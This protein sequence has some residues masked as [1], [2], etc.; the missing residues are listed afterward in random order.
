MTD[1]TTSDRAAIPTV[2]F[3]VCGCCVDHSDMPL[4]AN[5]KAICPEC[6]E[7]CSCPGCIAEEGHV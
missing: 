7:P 1:H 2:M 3:W 6:G 5:K 4:V